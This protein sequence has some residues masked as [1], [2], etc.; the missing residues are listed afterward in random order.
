ME[1][2]RGRFNC[3]SLFSLVPLWDGFGKGG[4]WRV[5]VAEEWGK[6]TQSLYP[7]PQLE[8]NLEEIPDEGLLV[9]WAFS[10]RPDLSLTVLPKLQAREV[11][12]QGWGWGKEAEQGGEGRA[13]GPTSLF[14][15]SPPCREVRSK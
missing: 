11:W 10:D 1:L 2:G 8:V 12:E 4:S 7:C 14:S 15:S 9:S 13:G 3:L 5:G 6:T